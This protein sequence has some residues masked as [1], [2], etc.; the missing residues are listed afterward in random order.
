MANR[1]GFPPG[2]A[3]ENWAILRALSAVLGRQ[4]PYD[5]LPELRRQMVAAAPHLAAIDRVP[6]NA[7]SAVAPAEFGAGAF[8]CPLK[9]VAGREIAG[10]PDQRGD[11]L[12]ARIDAARRQ[13]FVRVRVDGE[14]YD[15]ADA[16][17]LDKYKRHSIEVIVDRYIVRHAEA[18]EGAKRGTDGR[19][20]VEYMAES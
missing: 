7:W 19:P 5:S 2:E 11:L 15:I 13:G 20:T 16:P 17:T 1:A 14:Q 3:R 6:E 10:K 9:P 18:P 4:L 12:A 8:D